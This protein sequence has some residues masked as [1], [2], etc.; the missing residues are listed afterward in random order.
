[1]KRLTIRPHRPWRGITEVVGLAAIAALSWLLYQ[2]SVDA[3]ATRMLLA[4]RLSELHAT[5]QRVAE[6]ARDNEAL[7]ERVSMLG[8]T[9]Q[10]DDKAYDDVGRQIVKLQNRILSLK[11]EVAF[12]RGIVATEQGRDVRVQTLFVEPDVGAGRYRFQLVLTR[13]LNNDKV[14]VGK[15]TLSVYGEDRGEVIELPYSHLNESGTADLDFRFKYFQR[16]E[17]RLTLPADFAPRRIRIQVQTAGDRPRRIER[18]FDWPS[19][20][21]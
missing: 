15:V 9:R 2:V 19:M 17:G 20:T 6:L 10:V 14:S 8:R 1:M 4:D 3:R 21:S 7:Q 5:H 11:E 18:A 13:G 16:L 12:Y